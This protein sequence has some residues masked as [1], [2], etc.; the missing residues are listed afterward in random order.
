MNFYI[1]IGPPGSGKTTYC[2]DHMGPKDVRVCMDDIQ[3]MMGGGIYD[4]Y[5][6]DLRG[7]YEHLEKAAI[8]KCMEVGRDVW[9]DRTCMAASRRARYIRM[10]KMYK[11]KI[12]A[13]NFVELG[14]S[15]AELLER[16]MSDPRGI[17]KAKWASFIGQMFKTYNP[18][19]E[20]EGIDE[21]YR[22]EFP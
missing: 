2:R 9:L 13:I 19:Q 3:Q 4:N 18:P 1:L 20:S 5:R 17:T 6:Q 16:R 22:W 11:P 15:R 10:V 7:V 14:L 21:I 12:T 8:L